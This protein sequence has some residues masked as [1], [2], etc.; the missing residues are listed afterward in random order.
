[1]RTFLA[2]LSIFAP[3]WKSPKCASISKGVKVLWY[4]HII[5]I[6]FSKK[7]KGKGMDH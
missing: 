5:K 1:M 4:V 7:K 6:L 3:N 2:T